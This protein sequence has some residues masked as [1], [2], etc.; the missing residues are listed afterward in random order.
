MKENKNKNVCERNFD[1]RVFREMCW[2]IIQQFTS[3][4]PMNVSEGYP[5][6]SP[7]RVV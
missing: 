5:T 2:E 7:Q 1:E 6:D 3:E 4:G